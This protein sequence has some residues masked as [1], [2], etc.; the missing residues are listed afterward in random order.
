[1][2]VLRLDC[3]ALP[4]HPSRNDPTFVAGRVIGQADGFFRVNKT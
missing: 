2:I 4:R 3:I 1:L